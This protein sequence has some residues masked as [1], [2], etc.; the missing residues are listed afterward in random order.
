MNA[1][2]GQLLVNLR[3]YHYLALRLATGAT[4]T[5]ESVLTA[6]REANTGLRR[7]IEPDAYQ[8][9]LEPLPHQW[10][11]TPDNPEAKASAW[12]ALVKVSKRYNLSLPP[13]AGPEIAEARVES[14]R[15]RKAFTRVSWNLFQQA[16]GDAGA[17]RLAKPRFPSPPTTSA[18]LPPA[19]EKRVDLMPLLD[20]PFDAERVEEA[21]ALLQEVSKLP[22]LEHALGDTVP[23][24]D[25]P[26]I[27][28][29]TTMSLLGE[30]LVYPSSPEPVSDLLLSVPLQAL[31]CPDSGPSL[32]S[33]TAGDLV[34]MGYA[35]QVLGYLLQPQGI[36]DVA[37]WFDR[38]QGVQVAVLDGTPG[39][40]SQSEAA[41][42]QRKHA[43][44]EIAG[45]F[46]YLLRLG[47]RPLELLGILAV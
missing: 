1:V 18:R 19:W 22:E 28:S 15:V 47:A 16:I 21:E 32:S 34:R 36:S 27:N 7:S 39:P 33:P 35:A 29:M 31:M 26:A 24:R 2:S 10:L 20:E 9:R 38:A 41:Q 13:G 17:R 25:F 23:P 46:E 30:L 12:D 42:L 43:I 8:G 14:T 40:Q 4:P 5:R 11:D 6:L 3:A 37:L 44:E 45:S